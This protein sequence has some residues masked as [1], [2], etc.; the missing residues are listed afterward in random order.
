VALRGTRT[1]W[2]SV[3]LSGTQWHSAVRVG[4]GQGKR[5][6]LAASKV[7]RGHPRSSKVIRG[8]QS[9]SW[10]IPR[11]LYLSQPVALRVR[12][13]EH[14][15]PSAPKLLMAQSHEHRLRELARLLPR[16]RRAAQ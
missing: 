15:E 16:T 2:H 10:G 1:Q 4:V 3:A 9:H 8:H 11:Q 12:S 7:L 6:Q 13:M 14:L 5:P